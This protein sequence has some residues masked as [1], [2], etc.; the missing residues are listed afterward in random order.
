MTV[1][2]TLPV[3]GGFLTEKFLGYFFAITIS[4][5]LTIGG[6]FTLCFETLVHFYL[7][8]ALFS[9]GNSITVTCLYVILGR[10]LQHAKHKRVAGFTITYTCM[11]AGALTVTLG[12]GW[13]IRNWGYQSAFLCSTILFLAATFTFLLNL[14]AITPTR[15]QL[16]QHYTPLQR[17]VGL[18]IIFFMIPA[19]ML[20]LHHPQFSWLLLT[21]VCTMATFVFAWLYYISNLKQ[22]KQLRL[23]LTIVLFGI[24]F[25]VLYALEPATL[26]SFIERNVRHVIGSFSIPLSDFSSINMLFVVFLGCLFSCIWIHLSKRH[27]LPAL[28]YQFALG[29]GCIGA[30][31]LLLSAS[32]YFSNQNG[33]ISIAWVIISSIMFS[34]A[35]LFI[36]P[37]GI[38]MV[39]TLTP[40][41][42]EGSMMGIWLLS[43]G[44]GSTLA[45]VFVS[46]IM[47]PTQT[48]SPLLTNDLYSYRFC[49][50][51][52]IALFLATILALLTPHLLKK[53]N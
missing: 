35:E 10:I 48:T 14:R 36:S 5:C 7:G 44:F 12:S 4:L 22:R 53:M 21:I 42:Y 37:V 27:H 26:T 19:I 15:L 13:I 23:F 25:W 41:K 1:I 52:L 39:G 2:F 43:N 18:A 28:P 17:A 9:I 11:N 49:E 8:L 20:L 51:G 32:T 40:P 50:F 45:G 33:L 24:F 31:Y 29:I 6:L 47:L 3:I 38:A 16:T 30:A 46:L 34:A